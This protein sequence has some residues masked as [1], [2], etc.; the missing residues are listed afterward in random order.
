MRLYVASILPVGPYLIISP[1][2]DAVLSLTMSDYMTLNA[3]KWSKHSLLAA[4]LQS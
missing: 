2:A 1:R 3:S 4:N